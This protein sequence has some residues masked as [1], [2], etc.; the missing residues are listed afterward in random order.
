AAAAAAFWSERGTYQGPDGELVVGREAIEAGYAELF[1][2][3]VP[4]RLEI[5]VELVRRIAPSVMVE[6][7]NARFVTGE[8]A[9]PLAYR[10][11]HVWTPE[12]WKVDKVQEFAA[13][14]GGEHRVALEP[15]EFLI[16][17]WVDAGDGFEISM[18]CNWSKNRHSLLRKFRVVEADALTLEG[19]QII[20]WDARRG[21][22]RSWLFDSAGGISEGTWRDDGGRWVVTSVQTQADGSLASAVNLITPLDGS[23]YEWVSTEREIDGIPAPPV[24]PVVVARVGADD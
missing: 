18:T 8:E 3:E 1:A 14:A 22:I 5:D 2:G 4:V 23:R 10:A 11:T 13:D 6:E 9:R 20:A 7:G 15:L 17:S 24:G 19:T 21:Q 12:G 16:G